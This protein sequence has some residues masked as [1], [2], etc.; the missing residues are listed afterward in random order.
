MM[1][2]TYRGH[3]AMKSLTQCQVVSAIIRGPAS[4]VSMS[5]GRGSASSRNNETLDVKWGLDHTT[6]GMIAAGAILVSFTAARW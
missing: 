2:C 1:V 6:P 3:T 4:V 5:E